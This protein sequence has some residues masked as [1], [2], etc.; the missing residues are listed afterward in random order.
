MA[1]TVTN[2][3]LTVVTDGL[4]VIVL[5]VWLWI[6]NW[7]LTLL[8][9]ALLPFSTL[10]LRQMSKRFRKTSHEIQASMGEISQVTQEAAEG[11]RVV[12]AFRGEAV[13]IAAFRKA[14][15]RSRRQVMRKVAV[16]SIGMSLLQVLGA[17]A[18]AL[19]IHI[20]L[21]TGEITAGGFASYIAATIWMMGPTRRLA[22]VNE[23]I[24]TGL[25]AADSA[26]ALLDEAAEDDSGTRE[27]RNVRGDIEYRGVT[28]R[29]DGAQR[30]ALC[31]VSFHVAA[32]QTLALVGAS[33]SGKTTCASLLPRFYR[34]QQGEIRLDGVNINELTLA[35]LRDQIALVGQEPML[36]DDTLRNNIAYGARGPVDEARVLEAARAAHVLEFASRLPQGLDTP[37]GER[38]IR[39]SGGQRQRVAI[40]RALYKNAPILVLDEAT[41]ALDSESERYVQVAVQELMRNRTTLVI[42]HR[43]STV[44]RADQIV[45]LNQGRVAE[46]GTHRELLA[47]NGIY[48]ALY[49]NQ[50]NEAAG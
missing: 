9:A 26:F 39:L 25:A 44:E 50:L 3:L 36:F 12:K 47:R 32:G 42:A 46:C 20:A 30:P 28:F 23:Q 37:L 8:F 2:V 18:L 4:T 31:E 15:E 49:R 16:S 22:K 45:V 27:L 19:V 35:N 10:M 40:A 11:Q 5:F 48:A 33:G 41:S 1:G 17:V 43:L 7:K 13:E 38:G 29:Y 21:T 14:S 6:L 24:Q 34:V